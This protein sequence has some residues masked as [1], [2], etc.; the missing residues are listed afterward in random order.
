MVASLLKFGAELL[1]VSGLLKAGVGASVLAIVQKAVAW[2]KA[3]AV[4]VE[5]D[6]KK[7]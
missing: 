3:K 2:L 5:A 1:T 4:V 6:V 7:L